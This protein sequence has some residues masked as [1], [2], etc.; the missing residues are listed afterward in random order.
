MY[1]CFRDARILNSG[2]WILYM[3]KVKYSDNLIGLRCEVCKR[4]NYYTR[5][6]KKTIERKITFEKFCPWDRKHTTHK[7]VRITGK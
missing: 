6:N 7:E 3:A 1:P 4:R 5:K 2:Y